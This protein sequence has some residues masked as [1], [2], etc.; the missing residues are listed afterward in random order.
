[1][2]GLSNA[3]LIQNFGIAPEAPRPVRVGHDSDVVVGLLQNAA[4]QW[5]HAEVAE[6]ILSDPDCM[7]SLCARA[8][9][10]RESPFPLPDH[11]KQ[12]GGV[13]GELFVQRIVEIRICRQFGSNLEQLDRF[14][15]SRTGSGRSNSVLTSVKICVFAAIPSAIKIAATAKNPG[16]RR[17]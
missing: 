17:N 12:A 8:A 15:G 9:L 7:T 13:M 3:G 1:M 16:D 5:P 4:H 14:C 6:E 2:S 10:Q 11:V